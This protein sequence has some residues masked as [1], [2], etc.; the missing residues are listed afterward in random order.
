MSDQSRVAVIR[1][2]EAVQALGHPLRVRILAALREPASAASVARSVG[3][4]R[5][6]VNYHL[7]ELERVGLVRAVEQRMVGNL[8][9]TLFL[10][11]GSSFVLADDALWTDARRTQ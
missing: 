4:P 9:E 8:V 1:N 10:A 7:K 6:K 11:V 2:L 5:Q 3:E